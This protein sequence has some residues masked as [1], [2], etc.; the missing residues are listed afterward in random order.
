MLSI[1]AIILAPATAVYERPAFH[2]YPPDQN[3]DACRIIAI[4]CLCVGFA[5][6]DE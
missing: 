4:P 5:R 1:A 3:V 6:L 2:V